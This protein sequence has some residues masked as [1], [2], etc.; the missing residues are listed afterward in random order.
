ME[1][2]LSHNVDVTNFCAVVSSTWSFASPALRAVCGRV[3]HNNL[4]QLALRDEFLR[5][6][7]SDIVEILKET[8]K[9][10]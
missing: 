9:Y 5:L 7:E 8:A 3:C 2:W 6:P 4:A 10:R 1:A